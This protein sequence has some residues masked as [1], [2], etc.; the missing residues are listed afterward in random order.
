MGTPTA[1]STTLD[2]VARAAGVSPATASR[3][4]VRR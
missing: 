3:V 2:D 4:L 1:R